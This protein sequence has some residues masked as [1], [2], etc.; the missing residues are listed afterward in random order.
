MAFGVKLL[1]P[2]IPA[3]QVAFV[4]FAAGLLPLLAVPSLRHAARRVER[5][6]LVLYR[7]L[8][9]GIAVLLYFLSIEHIPVGV[10]TLLN[11]TSP[12][13][14]GLLAVL[15]LGDRLRLATLV[16][17]VAAFVGVA[18]V[19]SAHAPPGRLLGFGPWE[20]VGV[21]SATLSGAALVATRAARRTEGSW[22]IFA[23]FTFFGFLVCAPFALAGWRT[24]GLRDWALLAF[25]AATSIVNQLL[26]TW[27]FRWLDNV[28]AGVLQQVSVVVAMGLGAA[29]LG[30]TLTV[31]SVAG[32]LLTLAAV[33]AVLILATRAGRRAPEAPG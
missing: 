20:L 29:L 12:I 8:F 6:D 5:R 18:M 24:P 27:S 25:V 23:S 14:A 3:P 21:L 15:F 26:M 32:T 30:E 16:P 1:S 13:W 2:R 33:A 9:G 10:A 31:G 7:G 17:L 22:A 28:T 4:R 19:V 11:A